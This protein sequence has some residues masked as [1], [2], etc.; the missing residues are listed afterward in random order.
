MCLL[1]LLISFLPFS[2]LI[3]EQSFA[4]EFYDQKYYDDS[5]IELISKNP[6]YITGASLDK[7]PFDTVTKQRMEGYSMTPDADEYGQVKDFSYNICE[8]VGYSPSVDDN[9]LVW[10]YM[11]DALAFK[12]EISL[13]NASTKKL[14]WVFDSTKVYDMGTGW[15]QLCLKLSDFRQELEASAEVYTH[16][17]IKFLCEAAE[18][19]QDYESILTKTT[20]RISIYH[21]FTSKNANLVKKSGILNSLDKAYYKFSESFDIEG[22]VFVGDKLK[23]EA[24]SR[25]FEYFYIGKSDLSDYL[26]NSKYYWK[27]F[28]RTPKAA[29]VDLDFGDVVKFYDAGFYYLSIQLYEDL[30]VDDKRVFSLEKTI[31]S[32]DLVLGV[33]KMGSAFEV[34]QNKKVLI[35]LTMQES[36]V[37]VGEIDI[38][39]TNN[40]AEIESYY[41]E[42]GLLKIWVVG[43]VD[44]N[45]SLEISAE[46]KTKHNTSYQKFSAKASIQVKQADDGVDFFIVLLWIV[47][48]IFCIGIIIYLSISVVSSRKNDVK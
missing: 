33:F 3:I 16:V 48:G 42:D 24:P 15:K 18:Y 17:N 10:V 36:L 11:I 21:M 7:T 28:I 40:K 26:T 46:A 39:L 14:S 44:G 29:K 12:L 2:K 43:K 22:G 37:D 35:T 9:L 45:V 20:D 31:R 30:S 25:M 13:R 27:I 4:N 23:L 34:A 32:D 8:G 41:Q 1:A 19:E 5:T 47:F 38:S 6:T